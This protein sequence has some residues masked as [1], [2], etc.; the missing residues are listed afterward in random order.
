MSRIVLIA[1]LG[2]TGIALGHAGLTTALGLSETT[3]RAA[4]EARW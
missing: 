4:A 3:A 2:W 1:A